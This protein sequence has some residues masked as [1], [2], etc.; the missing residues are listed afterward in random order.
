MILY[1]VAEVAVGQP[2]SSTDKA[3]ARL[4]L[5]QAEKE[6]VTGEATLPGVVRL[7][8]APTS[9]MAAAQGVTVEGFRADVRELANGL[10]ELVGGQLRGM[11]DAPTTR[12]IR[13]NSPVV[14]LDISD[15]GGRSGM[16]I[17]MLC[18]TAWQRALVMEES[19]AGTR[20]R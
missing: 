1:A 18:A 2:L 14:V 11:F 4:A 10:G 12:G 15:T 7:M 5:E 16:G 3:M 8:F 6:S 20:D 17:V 13:F 9:D 19:G